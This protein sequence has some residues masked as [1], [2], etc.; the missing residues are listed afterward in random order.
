M[1][2]RSKAV[3]A[4]ASGLAVAAGGAGV[5]LATSQ[6][7]TAATDGQAFLKDV[8]GRL[9]V[10]ESNLSDALKAAEIDQ[11]DAALQAGR[12]TQ[13]QADAMK[14]AIES[15]AMPLGVGVGKPLGP[16]PFLDA[17]AAYLGITTSQLQS[18]LENGQT[19]AEVAKAE[20]KSVDGL[21]AAI[22]A[23]AR[24]HLDKDVSSGAITSGQEQDLLSHLSEHLD[25]IVN[26]TPPSGP[27]VAVTVA[28]GL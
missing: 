2:T 3:A 22:V 26:G 24:S 27:P 1:R 21:E 15:G 6:S 8:A 25:D 23:D 16:P 12:I 7:G 18:D 11:V 10:S 14:K 28:P 9:G 17:A 20:G 13:A 19:L 4:L 5:A